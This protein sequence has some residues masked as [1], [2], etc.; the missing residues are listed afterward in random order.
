MYGFLDKIDREEERISRMLRCCYG[1]KTR[2]GG[3]K[4]DGYLLLKNEKKTASVILQKAFRDEDGRRHRSNIYLGDISSEKAVDHAKKEY[5]YRLK[6]VLEKDLEIIR[7][8]KGRYRSYDCETILDSLSTAS[9]TILEKAGDFSYIF[10]VPELFVNENPGPGGENRYEMRNPSRTGYGRPVRSKGEALIGTMLEQYRITYTSEER[11]VLI[12]WDGS[13]VVRYPDFTVYGG[14]E[15]VHWEHMGLI[16]NDNYL[17][18]NAKKIQLYHR[19]GIVLWDNLII[20]M[21]GPGGS[22]NAEAID[23]IIRSFLLP[24]LGMGG[25]KL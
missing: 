20:T 19:N 21:D 3:G 25:R 9:R 7:L 11:L 6:E 4:E 22:V 18:D 24:R 1:D 5:A 12:D 13:K 23:E 8:I 2:I 17:F 15:K 10:D 16:E 14:S